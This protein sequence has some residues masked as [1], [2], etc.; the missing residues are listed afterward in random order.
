MFWTVPKNKVVMPGTM[1]WEQVHRSCH[2]AG[3]LVLF[4]PQ[5]CYCRSIINRT[6]NGDM[7]QFFSESV[8][9]SIFFILHKSLEGFLLRDYALLIQEII[10]VLIQEIIA[11]LIQEIIAALT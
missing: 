6:L 9:P 5:A 10:S 7:L 4:F 1:F 11:V 2:N 3:H 8:V